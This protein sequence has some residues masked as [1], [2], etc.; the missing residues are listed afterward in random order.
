[1]EKGI[2]MS[3]EELL[4]NVFR[5][6]CQMVTEQQ[7]IFPERVSTIIAD[8]SDIHRIRRGYIGYKKATLLSFNGKIWAMSIG[9]AWGDYP[10]RPY[11]SDIL[12]IEIAASEKETGKDVSEEIQELIHLGNSFR[13]SLIIARQNG[14]ITVAKNTQNRF[15][16]K[17]LRLLQPISSNF[18]AQKLEVDTNCISAINLEHPTISPVRY[19]PEFAEELAKQFAKILSNE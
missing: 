10:A 8:D 5:I 17:V 18:I 9:K 6:L 7:I 2:S 3:G 11:N 16:E 14:Q 19:T 15:R 13:H 12:A 1:M 4:E